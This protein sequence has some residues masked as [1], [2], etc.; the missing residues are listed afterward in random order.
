MSSSVPWGD[1]SR[2]ILTLLAEVGP[3]S[4]AEIC[5]HLGRDKDAIASVVSR[6]ARPWPRAPKRIHIRAYVYDQE[7]ERRYPRA[8]YA[9]GDRPD[10]PR[11]RPDTAANKARY[12]ANRKLRLRGSSIFNW[13]MNN[14]Q[15]AALVKQTKQ[16]EQGHE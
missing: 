16:K 9:I 4:R 6:L 11:P 15:L 5:A 12:W 14:R 8:V 3:M 1:L 7:G 10:A 2:R 13:G